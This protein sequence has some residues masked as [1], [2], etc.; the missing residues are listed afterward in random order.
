MRICPPNNQCFVSD[1]KIGISDI[2]ADRS[3]KL[4]RKKHLLDL[5]V[6]A[7]NI[8]ILLRR[9][10]IHLHGFHSAVVLGR[11]LLEDKIRVLV[12]ALE[13]NRYT[14]LANTTHI[15]STPLFRS[16]FGVRSVFTPDA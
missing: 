14:R 8:A 6:Q 10:L 11:Q 7:A 4:H 12:H 2:Y 5:L 15:R 3:R 9:P 1:T 13:T 16:Q